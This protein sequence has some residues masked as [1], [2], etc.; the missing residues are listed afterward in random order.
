MWN[1][2]KLILSL[3]YLIANVAFFRKFTNRNEDSAIAMNIWNLY[4]DNVDSDSEGVI[5]Y[6][7]NLEAENKVKDKVTRKERTNVSELSMTTRYRELT[8]LRYCNILYNSFV[9]EKNRTVITRWRL[10]C[11]PLR[12]E[13]GRYQRPRI[14]RNER[15]CS[16]CHT[17]EDEHHALFVC[18]AHV[19]IRARHTELLST[20]TT[21]STILHP[22]T[23]EDANSIVSYIRDIERNMEALKMVIKH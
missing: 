22:E 9:I 18:A 4:N 1:S 15:L 21:V 2:T 19:F 16:V 12:I 5:H 13:T 20:Y 23:V 6:F 8:N 10:S 14:P 11:H 7:Q 3:L 17:L